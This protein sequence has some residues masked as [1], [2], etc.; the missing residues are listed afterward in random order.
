MPPADLPCLL[1]SPALL[2]RRV[3]RSKTSQASI[4]WHD[5]AQGTL[6]ASSL[7]LSQTSGPRATWRLERLRPNGQGDWLPACPAPLL[8]EAASLAE[9]GHPIPAPLAPVAAFL[10]RHRAISLHGGS[11]L[12]GSLPGGHG[13]TQL[14]ILEGTLRGVAQD[15]PTCRILL[16]GEPASVAALAR[17]LGETVRLSVPRASLAAQA[18]AVASGQGPAPR[19]TG[20]PAIPPGLSVGGALALATAHL[21]DVILHWASLV[22]GSSGSNMP[23]PVH[24]M[25]VA[26]RRLRSAL[27]VF[28]RPAQADDAARPWLDELAAQLKTLAAQLGA[29]R[30]WDVFLAETGEAVRAAFPQ[31]R[32][33][34]GLLAAAARRRAV[35]YADLTAAFAGRAWQS[36]EM[37]LALLPTTRPWH[38][39]PTQAQAERLAAPVE[40]FAARALD[41]HLKHVLAPGQ[42]VAHLPAEQLH[43]IRKQAKRLRYA[44]EFFAPLFPEKPVRKYLSRLE[45]L[46]EVLGAVNDTAVAAGLMAQLGGGADRAFAAGIVQGFGAGRSAGA[47]DGVERAWAKF[48]RA[49]PFWD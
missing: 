38:D 3:G 10:G 43:D 17:A 23:E 33:V 22:P 18:M 42:G 35:A 13:A 11:L 28:R 8:A 41:R 44:I 12:G 45:H 14:S 49:P 39:D 29:A 36:L 15:R 47:A 30:D 4:V 40:G 20:A 1:R 32:R 2:S 31:D 37:D 6:A 25:R 34:A 19:H 24:Q 46:Q 27:S 16:Q 48:Y 21:A 5:T 7:S 9:L 26:V